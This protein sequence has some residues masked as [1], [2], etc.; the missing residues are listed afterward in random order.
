[1]TGLSLNIQKLMLFVC[2]Q[3]DRAKTII[4]HQNLSKPIAHKSW[5]KEKM[6]VAIIIYFFY[7]FPS[8]QRQIPSDQPVQLTQ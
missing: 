1:M 6:L 2:G 4:M 8:I 7:S 3:T 5:D